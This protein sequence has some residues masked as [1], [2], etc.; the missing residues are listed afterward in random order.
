MPALRYHASDTPL[1]GGLT[2]PLA[3]IEYMA[4]TK[5]TKT[6]LQLLEL[7]AKGSTLVDCKINERTF[8][9]ETILLLQ[10]RRLIDED[11]A[12]RGNYGDSGYFDL[13][14]R[15]FITDRGRAVLA[16]GGLVPQKLSARQREVLL[17]GA[18]GLEIILEKRD[19]IRWYYQGDKAVDTLTISI[20]C[21]QG[22]L[23]KLQSDQD[24]RVLGSGYTITEKGLALVAPSTS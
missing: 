21:K 14:R 6:Q 13:P 5:L 16:K 2:Q 15:Y 20:L 23:R 8:S 3:G 4:Q 12:G 24:N 18:G 7:L 9:F 11:V 17:D 10:R 19:D 1:R 22:Y